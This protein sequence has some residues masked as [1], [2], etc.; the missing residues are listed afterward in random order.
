MR[1]YLKLRGPIWTINWTDAGGGSHSRSTRERDY[2]R[3]QQALAR[4]TLEQG[5]VL[6]D[7][8]P[9]RVTVSDVV[10]AYWHA[11][12]HSRFANDTLK[13]VVRLVEDE[14][15]GLPVAGVI[16]GIIAEVRPY[17][18]DSSP[19]VAGSEPEAEA[20]KMLIAVGFSGGRDRD[21]TC[22]PFH[23]KAAGLP[24]FQGLT[25]ANDDSGGQ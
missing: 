18:L 6:G 23:V 3:A 19:T 16:E 13:T 11:R 7:A 25:V 8:D 15:K 2:G 5:I 4:F 24:G 17:W 9:R 22:D 20:S 12:G 10:A 21:R 1:Y 14:W